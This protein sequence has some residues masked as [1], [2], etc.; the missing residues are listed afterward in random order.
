M[1]YIEFQ[2]YQSLRICIYVLESF[3]TK[4]H[5]CHSIQF[6]SYILHQ[7]LLWSQVLLWL[8]FI[9]SPW[10]HM[11][12]WIKPGLSRESDYHIHSHQKALRGSSHKIQYLINVTFSV[13]WHYIL[14]KKNLIDYCQCVA[15]LDAFLVMRQVITEGKN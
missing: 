14:I 11:L 8:T 2:V 10:L 1:K 5:T 9:Q 12:Q 3:F 15:L 7:I 4:M 13:F 6:Y